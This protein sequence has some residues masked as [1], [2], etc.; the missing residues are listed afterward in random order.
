M[1][2]GIRG[3]CM[4]AALL[5]WSTA[6][7]A[8]AASKTAAE[9]GATTYSNLCTSCHGRYGRGDGPLAKSLRVPLPNFS[10][11]AWLAGRTDDEIAR[12][13]TQASHGPM[14]VAL[15]LEPTVLRDAIAYIRTLSVP[16]EHVSL[17]EGRDIYNAVCWVCHG[18]DGGGD[19]PAAENLIGPKPRDFTDPKFVI[20]GHEDEIAKTI[21]MGAEAS[22]HGSHLMPAWGTHLT[23][24]Q[25]RSVVEYLKTFQNH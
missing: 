18:R 16:G 17:V 1:G 23:P 14:A 22:F 13:L 21:S 10:D 11:S 3:L 15:V 7:H 4:V 6:V 8:E 19:G 2:A 25:I 9:R 20:A 24:E 5:V 12:G